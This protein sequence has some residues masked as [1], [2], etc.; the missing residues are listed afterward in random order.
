M[1]P[2]A[3]SWPD[4]Q[5]PTWPDTQATLHR[6]SQMLGKLR[7]ALSPPQN[8]YWHTTLYVSTHGLTTSPIPYGSDLFQVDFDF[9]RDQLLIETSWGDSA[10]LALEPR[11]VA[12]FYAHLMAALRKLGIDVHI[13]T[14]PVE[15]ADTTPF[16]QDTMHASYDPAAAHE[17]W[18]AL[19]QVDRVFKQFRGRFLGKASPVHFFW[20]G[21]DLAV[22]RFSGRRA[23]MWHGQTLNVGPHVMHES[24]SH[25]VS[26]AGFWL[27]NAAPP[28][29]YSYAVP[30]PDGFPN[31][32]VAPAAAG[33]NTE[34]GEFVLPYEAV[35][36]SD[37][38]EQML[39]SFLESTYAAAADLGNWDRELLEHRPAC[40]CT[41]HD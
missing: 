14:R 16:D 9:L 31:A 41:V 24:Y 33:Y 23:P 21:F 40:G 19:I 5:E 20:G 25:E 32:E 12:D 26:S 2:L 8:H 34:M 3:S 37:N 10:T 7:L 18:R 27:G 22:T 36:T 13:W 15:I 39:T 17:F 1:R 35:R 28:M 29:F 38:P 6:W 4:L 11:S 30:Q